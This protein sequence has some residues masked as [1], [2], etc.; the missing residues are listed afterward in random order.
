MQTVQNTESNQMRN[1]RRRGRGRKAVPVAERFV[2]PTPKA[3]TEAEREEKSKRYT[4]WE[5]LRNSANELQKETTRACLAYLE[6]KKIFFSIEEKGRGGDIA[7]DVRSAVGTLS[8]VFIRYE[9]LYLL[10]CDKANAYRKAYD[11][12]DSMDIKPFNFWSIKV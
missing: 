8:R 1:R 2:A 10:A 4:E 5:D 9:G 12:W 11:V 7:E 6:V 3:L